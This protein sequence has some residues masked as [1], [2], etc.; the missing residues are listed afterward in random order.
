M[1]FPVSSAPIYFLMQ[2]SFKYALTDVNNKCSSVINRIT[3]FSI[4][5]PTSSLQPT[6]T[7]SGLAGPFR[8][9][10]TPESTG[11]SSLVF[12]GSQ[13]MEHDGLAARYAGAEVPLTIMAVAS[14]TSPS[15]GT[16]VVWA[17]GS[18]GTTPILSLQY[19]GG[20]IVLKQISSAGTA[21]CTF[22][23]DAKLHVFTATKS[24]TAL[25]LRVDGVQVA[26]AAITAATENFTT[27][28]VGAQN[29]NGSVSNFL[30]GT[31]ATI[32]AYGGVADVYAAEIDQLV[33]AG[34]I[35]SPSQGLNTGF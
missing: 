22:A 17:L 8:S 11:I 31:T 21:T 32:A 2:P 9:T 30:T 12:G 25:T 18:A 19:N 23:T 5:Q 24:A 28:V 10:N 4:I 27:F 29:N 13:Y 7:G 15:T 35:R 20:N 3:Q 6:L 33:G 26:T 16:Q 14:C 1:K 34:I